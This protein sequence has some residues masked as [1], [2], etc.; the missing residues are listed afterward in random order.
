VWYWVGLVNGVL[1]AVGGLA[2]YLHQD[3]L[4]YINPN[5][6]AL[7]WV[8][9]LFS[10]CLGIAFASGRWRIQLTLVVLAVVNTLWVFLSTSRSNLLLAIICLLFLALLLR[11]LKIMLAVAVVSVLM[12]SVAETQFADRTNRTLYR[13]DKLL[14]SSD[15]A[16]DR[17]SGRSDLALGA[18]YI[19]L[20]HP[21]GVGT[22][23]FAVAWASLGAREG[24]SSF[25]RGEAFAAHAAWTKIL[26]ENGLL[27]FLLLAAYL[28]SFSYIGLRGQ[29]R[30]LRMLAFFG[31]IGIG[32]AFTSTEFQSK[33]LWFL[34][35][36]ITVALNRT[37]FIRHLSEAKRRVPTMN[38]VH[39]EYTDR[40]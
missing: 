2:Y 25:M 9:A 17:T 5:V 24:L 13:F 40:G 3:S 22:G 12:L 1:G 7:F 23:G 21:L 8:A 11:N 36:G 19:F 15:T 10:I 30:G 16:T 31:T 18:W 4:P 35:A 28:F 26:A 34:A 29:D 6:G 39:M 33:G 14:D 32:V 38:I 27:G 37:V 20:D